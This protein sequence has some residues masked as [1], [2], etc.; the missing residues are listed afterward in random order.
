MTCAETRRQLPAPE[1]GQ[2]AQSDQHIADCAPCRSELDSLREV[3]RRVQ[4][5]GEAR[6]AAALAAWALL[7]S[8]SSGPGDRRSRARR[9]AELSLGSAEVELPIP[10]HA[11]VSAQLTARRPSAT[12]PTSSPQLRLAD[13]LGAIRGFVSVSIATLI[14]LG[15][16]WLLWR[17]LH[18]RASH[19]H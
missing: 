1:P 18:Y 17:L 15:L 4:R 7:Q 8:S 9:V 11:V 19:P 5:L 16:F 3:D 10:P 6:R 12:G 13:H 2:A 14:P